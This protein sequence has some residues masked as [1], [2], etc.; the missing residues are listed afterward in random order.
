MVATRVSDERGM[1]ATTAAGLYKK[2]SA[3]FAIKKKTRFPPVS[4]ILH[5]QYW[6]GSSVAVLAQQQQQQQGREEKEKTPKKSNQ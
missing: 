2:I 3:R 5:T 1:L 4:M 6:Y